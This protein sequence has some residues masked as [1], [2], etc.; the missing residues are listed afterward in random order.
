MRFVIAFLFAASVASAQTTPVTEVNTAALTGP[1]DMSPGRITYLTIHAPGAFSPSS[2]LPQVLVHVTFW[3]EACAHLADLEVC[4]TKDDSVVLDLRNLHSVGLDNQQLSSS[5]DL[6][7][8]RGAWTAHAFESDARC[9]DPGDLGYR[10]VPESITG[11]WSIADVATHG[12]FGDR[13]QGLEVDA[14]GDIAVP[15]ERFEAL[16]VSFL[17]PDSLSAS[18]LAVWTVLERGGDLP[19]EIGPVR[20]PIAARASTFDNEEVR[21]SLPDVVVGCALFSSLIPGVGNV[22]PEFAMPAS[23]GFLRLSSP[24]F[25]EDTTIVGGDVWI[26]AHH[27]EMLGPFGTGNRAS[28]VNPISLAPTPTPSASPTPVQTP[29]GTPTLATATPGVSPTPSG[30]P[31]ASA[32]PEVT[33]TPGASATPIATSTPE[34]SATPAGSISGK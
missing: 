23:S 25:V 18:T 21:L 32:T 20:V 4:L 17:A 31:G 26:Y 29:V 6:T 11:T 13:A 15:D 16:D 30:T 14:A 2:G 34:A 7:G 8:Q 1:F 28:Y 5:F 24:R 19:H 10:L 9:R 3:S 33:A 12:A 27:G 22:I